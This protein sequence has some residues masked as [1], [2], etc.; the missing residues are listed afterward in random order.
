MRAVGWLDYDQDKL[1]RNAII[2]DSQLKLSY[3][4][5]SKEVL[6]SASYFQEHNFIK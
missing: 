1:L 3:F 6:T 4:K 2:T 5:F